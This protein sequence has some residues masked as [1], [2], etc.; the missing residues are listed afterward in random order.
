VC[1]LCV[2]V[3]CVSGKRRKKRKEKT[4]VLVDKRQRDKKDATVITPPLFVLIRIACLA[5]PSSYSLLDFIV[6]IIRPTTFS[7]NWIPKWSCRMLETGYSPPNAFL[8]KEVEGQVPFLFIFCFQ[9][10]R[11]SAMLVYSGMAVTF[12]DRLVYFAFFS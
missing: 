8:K 2:S 1:L 10:L 3:F 5:S 9:M 7:Q 6:T 11:L 12:V 4:N